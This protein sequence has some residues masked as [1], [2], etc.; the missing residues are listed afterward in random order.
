MVIYRPG[1]VLKHFYIDICY[2]HM[3]ICAKF[4]INLYVFFKGKIL[5]IY[6]YT[7]IYI[8][9]YIIYICIY[10]MYIYYLYTYTLPF[11]SLGS[12]RQFRVFHENSHFYLSNELQNV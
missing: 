9:I 7:Y 10:I 2:I 5:K 11:K 6:I 12:P 8:C 1:N 3:F 4:K